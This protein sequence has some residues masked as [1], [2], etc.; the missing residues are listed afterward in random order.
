M[1]KPIKLP[2]NFW[3]SKKVLVTGANGFMGR[4]LLTALCH[5]G[6]A[7][8]ALIPDI[9]TSYLPKL[10][11]VKYRKWDVTQE[12]PRICRTGHDVIFH[13]ASQVD[14][15]RA[16]R[17]PQETPAA[18]SGFLRDWLNIPPGNLC[19]SAHSRFTEIRFICRLMKSN[20]Q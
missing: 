17:N 10:E 5:R 7:I 11:G 6:A 1:Q 8:D 16:E 18:R 14:L 3:K 20:F 15:L 4:H 9:K 19:M 2:P 13:L 12:L